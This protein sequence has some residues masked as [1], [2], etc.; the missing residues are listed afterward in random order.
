M[1]ISGKQLARALEKHGWLLKRVQGSHHIY[2][3]PGV[4]VRISIPIHGNQSLKPGLSAHLL[5][6]AGLR[7]S[8]V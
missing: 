7:E 5:K 3:K 1:A 6:M 8:D 2:A 4:E